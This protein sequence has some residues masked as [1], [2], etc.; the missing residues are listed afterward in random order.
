MT[1]MISHIIHDI[2]RWHAEEQA[3]AA[4]EAALLF[5]VM[6]TL[7]MG[8]FDI[9]NGI[10]VNQKAITASQIMADLVARNQVV[11]QTEI[12]DIIVAG[13]MALEPFPTAPF[14][15]DIVSVEF[16]DDEEPVVLWRQ[17][18][19]M[20]ENDTAVD[21]T[22]L[23]AEEGNGVVIVSVGYTFRPFFSNFVVGDINMQ[24]VA[25]LRGRRSATVL[26]TDCP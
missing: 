6:I 10:V 26:C 8:V 4:V 21:S 11:N 18:F 7:L 16:D 15:Y 9:G 20:T 24:E 12:N 13:R 1:N 17:T 19:N 23:I 25:F 14:G 5:P 22:G 2:K 3:V